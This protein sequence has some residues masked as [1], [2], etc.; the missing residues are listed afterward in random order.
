MLQPGAPN[1]GKTGGDNLFQPGAPETSKFRWTYTYRA[2]NVSK[3]GGPF[4]A[5]NYIK[6]KG[7]IKMKC[8]IQACVML[9]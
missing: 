8:I 4:F 2:A 5:P 3:F 7:L 9:K 6:M 1:F